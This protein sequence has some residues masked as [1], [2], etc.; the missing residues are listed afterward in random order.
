MDIPMRLLSIQSL[1]I[2]QSIMTTRFLLVLAFATTQF[3][4]YAQSIVTDASYIEF[5]VKNLGKTVTGTMKNMEGT[6]Q[7]NPEDLAASSFE[8]TIE[9]NTVHTGVKGRDNHLRKD[10]FFGIESYP[11]IKMVSKAITKTDKGYQAVATLFLKEFEKEITIP[12]TV[13]QEGD[14]RIFE[15]AFDLQRKEYEL[16][17]NMGKMM[18]GLDVTVR[19]HAV[20]E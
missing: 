7:W 11:K 12:F 3:A 20:V 19:I 10:D 13:K 6:I 14:Q 18:I 1:T 5:D 17:A 2:K 15:G 16:G 8:A 4:L 9:P